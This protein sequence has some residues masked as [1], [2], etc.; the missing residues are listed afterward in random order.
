[1]LRAWAKVEMGAE[2]HLGRSWS[3][4][5]LQ[6]TA[7]ALDFSQ[8]PRFF[9]TSA[10]LIFTS[11]DYENISYQ[12]NMKMYYRQENMKVFSCQENMKMY[13]CQENMRIFLIRGIWKYF[14]KNTCRI[15]KHSLC[16]ENMN[17]EQRPSIFS[18]FS[19]LAGRTNR[20][21][22]FSRSNY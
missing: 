15:W 4:L 18:L 21:S 17:G 11:G 16:Q 13:S 6:G 8:S 10:H 22:V 9:F 1:M 14:F 5:K 2:V 3:S 12:E 20:P 19:A 7:F